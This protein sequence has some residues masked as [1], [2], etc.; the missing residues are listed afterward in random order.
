MVGRYVSYACSRGRDMESL[1]GHVVTLGT[2]EVMGGG[3][4]IQRVG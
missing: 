2:R 3:M 1:P 4:G